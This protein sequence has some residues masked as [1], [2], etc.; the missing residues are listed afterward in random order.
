MPVTH[1]R[2]ACLCHARFR[3]E[4]RSPNKSLDL[5]AEIVHMVPVIIMVLMC[6]PM[7]TLRDATPVDLFFSFPTY[8]FESL[9]LYLLECLTTEG[10][11]L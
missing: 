9:E 6:R 1:G 5:L 2:C 11:E 4:K 3:V 7:R 8:G 10:R